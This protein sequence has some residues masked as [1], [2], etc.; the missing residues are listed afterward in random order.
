VAIVL[1]AVVMLLFNIL[2]GSVS[3]GNAI[4]AFGEALKKHRI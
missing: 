3:A 2:F 1:F 4:I